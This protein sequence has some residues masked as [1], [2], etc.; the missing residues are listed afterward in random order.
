MVA[1][2]FDICSLRTGQLVIVLQADT[3]A[4]TS[5]I[6]VAPVVHSNPKEFVE[7]LNITFN[8]GEQDYTVR[9]QEMSAI[10]PRF[11]QNVITNKQD[12]HDKFM[13]AVDLLF[14]GFR[15]N[16][17]RLFA[18]PSSKYIPSPVPTQQLM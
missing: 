4:T 17:P 18:K 13:L 3:S 2:Q 9:M 16:S 10:S 8:L 5:T 14:A 7:K 1:S 15:P 12:L 6:I 11:I